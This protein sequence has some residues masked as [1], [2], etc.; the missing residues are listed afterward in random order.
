LIS[1]EE[2]NKDLFHL[3][4]KR[5]NSILNELEKDSIVPLI[6]QKNKD[7]FYYEHIFRS[8]NKFLMD[9]LTWEV[10]FFNDFY[11]LGIQQS[12]LHLNSIFKNSVTAIF[13]SINKTIVNK[14]ND[15]FA[16]SLMIIVN[17]E[18][19]KLTPHIISF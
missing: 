1:S 5:K 14:C 13:D 12:S 10:L 19:K 4:N 18:Q 17:Y 8:L 11:D 3:V 7:T 2:L 15:F 9:L 16:I 6:A